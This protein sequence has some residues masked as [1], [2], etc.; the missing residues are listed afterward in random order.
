MILNLAGLA[1]LFKS[2]NA[3]FQKAFAAAET[4]WAQ[5]A[6]KIPSSTE[7]NLYAFL[8][9]FPKMREWVGDRQLKNMKASNYTL[10][11]KQ[12]ESS[13]AVPKPKIEDDTY[14]VFAPMIEFMGDAAARH[15]DELVFAALAAGASALCYDGQYFFDTDHPIV[16]DGAASTASNY[17]ATGGGNL[18][19]LLDTKRPLKPLIYQE[20]QPIKFASF[21]KDSDE[22]VFM[23][24]EF[25]YGA[26]GRAAAGYGLWQ[27]AYGS[28]NT[29]DST[30]VQAYA[31]TMMALK[32]DEGA[33]LGIMPDTCVVGPSNWA[34]ARALFLVPTLSGGAANPNFGLCKVLVSPYLT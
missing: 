10:E 15:P 14:G 17:D 9:H 24:N 23:R 19:A 25:V 22:H 3:A 12:F 16:V 28:L 29:L 34:A 32:S 31:A 30:N 21:Q 20:R 11:N 33:P 18:W 1:S 27:M 13:V 26:D 5:I 8:G 7:S 6:T 4:Q 2:F